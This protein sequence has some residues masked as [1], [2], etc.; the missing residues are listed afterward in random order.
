MPEMLEVPTHLLHQRFD[1]DNVAKARTRTGC[2]KPQVL[3]AE[4]DDF[5][6]SHSSHLLHLDPSGKHSMPKMMCQ[7]AALKSDGRMTKART[8]LDCTLSTSFIKEHL[9]QHLQPPHHHHNIQVTGTG[10][11]KHGLLSR[12]VVSFTVKNQI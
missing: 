7:A 6:T 10:N 5:S 9:A 11:A 12:S 1:C 2:V 8:L 3:P 4:V